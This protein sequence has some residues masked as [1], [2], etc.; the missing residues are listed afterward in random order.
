MGIVK[1]TIYS[2]TAQKALTQLDFSTDFQESNAKVTINLVKSG[3]V[4]K[5]IIYNLDQNNLIK[6]VSLD[7]PDMNSEG[8]ITL[9]T[10]ANSVVF[11]GVCIWGNVVSFR[12]EN[13]AIAYR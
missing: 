5:T 13:V 1:S 2:T 7:A 3:T 8:T 6:K 10:N 4:V 9:A 12:A 11:S